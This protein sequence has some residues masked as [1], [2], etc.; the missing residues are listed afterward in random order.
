MATLELNTDLSQRRSLEE[1]LRESE[2]RLSLLVANVQDYAI[3]LLSGA[4]EVLTWNEGAERLEGYRPEEI[5]GQSFER[6]YT[7]E[8]I[9]R[10]LPASLLAEASRAGRAQFEGWRVR[11]DGSRFWADVVITA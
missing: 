10:G 3:F 9:A 8:A 4:G 5:I 1:S 11:K 7:P 2:G 6:F